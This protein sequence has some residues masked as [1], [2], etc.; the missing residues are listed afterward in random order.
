MA[1]EASK[2]SYLSNRE[3]QCK[4]NGQISSPK[5]ISCG[6]PQGSILGPL[7]FLLYINGMP[8]FIKY[9]SYS[10]NVCG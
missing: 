3:Q 8:K 9:V 2:E 6:I 10:I 1:S 4:F 7:L 5:D